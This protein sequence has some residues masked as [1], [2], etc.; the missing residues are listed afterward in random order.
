MANVRTT[1]SSLPPPA[2]L[3]VRGYSHTDHSNSVLANT[4]GGVGDND[5]AQYLAFGEDVKDAC[6]EADTIDEPA[7][8]N[9]KLLAAVTYGEGSTKDNYEEMAGIASVLVRQKKAR[10]TTLAKL[11]GPKSTFA[12]AAS[13]G[14][15]RFKALTNAKPADIKKSKGMCSAITAAKNAMDGGKDYSNGAYYWDGADIKSNYTNHPKVK[16]GI[17]FGNTKHNI[18]GIKE[19]EMLEKIEYWKVNDK[20]GKLVQGKERGRYSHTYISTAAHGGTIFW[21][22]TDEFIKASGN[23]PHL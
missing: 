17:K 3:C 8:S 4:P 13:D 6:A 15:A 2:W 1:G 19:N 7:N 16:K 20:D 22:Y 18:Y 11:L 10:N 12:F 23:K 21:K 9:L 14:N 5:I